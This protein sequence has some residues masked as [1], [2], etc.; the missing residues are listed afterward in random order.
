MMYLLLNCVWAVGIY[1]LT[2]GDEVARKYA[3]QFSTVSGNAYLDVDN[4]RIIADDRTVNYASGTNIYFFA[5]HKYHSDA[6]T[7]SHANLYYATLWDSDGNLVRDFVPV[8]GSK[9][10]LGMYDLV[11]NKLYTNNGTG[12]DF[13]AGEEVNTTLKNKNFVW[14]NSVDDPANQIELQY[15]QKYYV[16]Y[17]TAN[18]DTTTADGKLSVKEFTVECNTH[19]YGAWTVTTEPTC[20]ATGE[21]QRVCEGCGHIDTQIIPAKSHDFTVE[22]FDKQTGITTMLCSVCNTKS[23]ITYP[24]TDQEHGHSFIAE[25]DKVVLPKCE[26]NGYTIHICENCQYT[27]QNNFTPATGHT[28]GEWKTIEEASINAAGVQQRVCEHCGATQ[29]RPLAALT[30]TT[31]NG[32]DKDNSAPLIWGI[33]IGVIAV[34]AGCGGLAWLLLAVFKP[35]KPK[36]GGTPK[37]PTPQQDKSQTSQFATA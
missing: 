28:F 10:E 32:G 17:Y 34:L 4:N 29:N 14:A 3:V 35:H 23:D 36:N 11:E 19:V 20:T 8:R 9:G 27:Y 26:E 16:Y 13:I 5:S 15:N 33:V 24:C 7:C 25:N 18:T 1:L 6:G 37:M 2:N 30:G 22:S 21:R 31:N 12:D